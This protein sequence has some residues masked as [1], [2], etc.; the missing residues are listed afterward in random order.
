[1]HDL[2]LRILAFTSVA[3]TVAAALSSI[4]C[5]RAMRQHVDT[6]RKPLL[7]GSQRSRGRSS[8]DYFKSGCEQAP[9][10]AKVSH[11]GWTCSAHP[12]QLPPHLSTE[13]LARP[14]ACDDGQLRVV[15]GL[16]ESGLIT[17][18]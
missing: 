1:M 11:S 8:G 3:A 16:R 17:A 15:D 6:I 7:Y 10:A 2:R 9:W 12:C 13:K 14:L 18:R 5:E 4:G